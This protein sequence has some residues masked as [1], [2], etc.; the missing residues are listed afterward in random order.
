M[1]EESVWPYLAGMLDGEGCITIIRHS[2]K[3][4]VSKRGYEIEPK[5][6]LSGM[7]QTHIEAIQKM[8]GLGNITRMV[9]KR[10]KAETDRIAYDLRYSPNE[11]RI[12][13]PKVIPYLIHKKAVSITLLEFLKYREQKIDR[14]EKEKGYLALEIRFRQEFIASKPWLSPGYTKKGREPWIV[15]EHPYAFYRTDP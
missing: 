11:Q 10:P 7:S 5:V 13:L 14:D 3:G 12:I 9:S 15:R 4:K 1:I 2:K 8:I 6:S